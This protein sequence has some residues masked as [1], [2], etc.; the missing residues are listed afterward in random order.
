MI[1][2]RYA[3]VICNRVTTATIHAREEHKDIVDMKG[4]T[5]I[6]SVECWECGEGEDILH[7]DSGFKDGTI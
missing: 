6:L 4:V 2:K 7:I 3:C 5:T 1:L